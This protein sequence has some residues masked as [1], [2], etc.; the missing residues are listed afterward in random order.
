MKNKLRAPEVLNQKEI[1]KIMK[2]IRNNED[3]ILEKI[4]RLEKEN[5][6]FRKALIDIYWNTSCHMT[7]EYLLNKAGI[8]F[9]KALK[10]KL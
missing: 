2:P 1:D 6:R 10:E 7:Q 5:N 9:K 4:K 8:D 3:I